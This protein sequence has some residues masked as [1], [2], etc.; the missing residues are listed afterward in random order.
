MEV[1]YGI[2][3]ME[4]IFGISNILC[5]IRG[6]KLVQLFVPIRVS[7]PFDDAITLLIFNVIV[8]KNSKVHVARTNT[9]VKDLISL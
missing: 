9:N 2:I 4:V 5:T 8:K 6:Y 3:E 1:H 7:E